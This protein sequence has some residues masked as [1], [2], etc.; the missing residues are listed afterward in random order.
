MQVW[1]YFV[2]LIFRVVLITLFNIRVYGRKN[3]P[4][5]GGLLVAS[6]HQSYLDPILIGAA[7]DRRLC[8]MARRTLF[9]NR[10]FGALLDRKSVV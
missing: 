1:W 7:I 6:N 8:F 2:Q 9:R 5:S 10:L 3:V 4:V